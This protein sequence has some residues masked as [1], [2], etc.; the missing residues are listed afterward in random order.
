MFQPPHIRIEHKQ[1]AAEQVLQYFITI[2]QS[3]KPDR[4]MQLLPELKPYLCLI[5]ANTQKRVEQITEQLQ[6]NGY[7]AEALHGGLAQNKRE[8]LLQQVR[9]VKFQY[10]VCTD[11]ASRGLDVEGVTHVINYDLPSDTESYIHRV[12]RTGRAGNEGTA[13]S[14]ITPRQKV[15][16]KKLEKAIRQRIEERFLSRPGTITEIRANKSATTGRRVP[17][18]EHTQ[19]AKLAGR[20]SQTEQESEK[21]MNKQVKPGYKKKMALAKKRKEQKEKRKR[22]QRQVNQRLKEMRKKGR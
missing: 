4:L 3:E 1:V 16:L 10:L 8:R 5:F 21:K 20:K 22:I 11:V 6:L 19:Q 7:E 17:D 18:T 12:G 2:N 15:Y 14:F 9:D 13:I